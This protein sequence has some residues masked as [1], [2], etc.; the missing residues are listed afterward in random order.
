MVNALHHLAAYPEYT[1][2]LRAEVEQV[3]TSD[4]WTKTAI[5]KMW[6]V[7]SFLRESQRS[8]TVAR[9]ECIYPPGLPRP[10]SCYTT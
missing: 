8:R 4:G 9:C 6:K 7:D 3:I 5:D 10:L 1:A 2:P